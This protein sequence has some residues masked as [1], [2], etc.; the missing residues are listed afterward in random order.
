MD[1]IIIRKGRPEDV[2][3]FSQLILLSTATFFPL[4]FASNTEEIMRN[5]FQQPGNL[6]SFEH[7][8]FIEVN[9]KI[10]GMALGYSWEQ[11]RR[12]E[13]H[14]GLL[15]VKYLKWNFLT[16]I[17]YF[18]KAQGIVGKLAEKEY[19]LSNIAVYPEF[20][21]LGV[22]TKL[23]SVIERESEK[24]CNNKIIL[25]VE[26][27]NKKAIKLYERL[28]YIIKWRT[29]SIKINK[30]IFEFFRMFKVLGQ[31]SSKVP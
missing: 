16:R 8:Y 15:L 13:L 17:F 4:L 26:T 24:T 30:E 22:G 11:K 27:N 10:A 18:L 19:Y 31:G 5:L 23:L 9:G 3:D 28:G 1:N 6:F 2:Q 20:R 21:G 7:S 12:E 29:P 25:D 14:T